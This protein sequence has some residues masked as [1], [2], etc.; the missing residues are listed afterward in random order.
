MK[1]LTGLLFVA[2]LVTAP[3]MAADFP[4]DC[5]SEPSITELA[6]RMYADTYFGAS[7]RAAQDSIQRTHRRMY[8]YCKKQQFEATYV[9]GF[10]RNTEFD[11][12][13]IELAITASTMD[14]KVEVRSVTASLPEEVFWEMKTI[15]FYDERR[16]DDDE[17]RRKVAEF[18]A[19]EQ[20][21]ASVLT[22]F[23]RRAA[24]TAARWA[25]GALKTE[26]NV[27]GYEHW[28]LWTRFAHPTKE[29]YEIGVSAA[30]KTSPQ[31]TKVYEVSL[32]SSYSGPYYGTGGK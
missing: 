14:N 9:Q 19:L 15:H 4:V 12:Q 23:N 32:G 8:A 2:A 21:L 24:T 18:A 11:A 6:R 22:I 5:A 27:R 26:R 29:N 13:R 7:L 16:F 3:A 30:V 31:G 10:I 1:H 20:P 28:D 17:A 25:N